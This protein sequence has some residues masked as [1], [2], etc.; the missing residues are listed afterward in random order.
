MNREISPSQGSKGTPGLE[1]FSRLIVA[2]SNPRDCSFIA[3]LARTGIR[4]SEAVQIKV[5]QRRQ[6]MIPIDHYTLQLLEVYLQ[7]RRRYPY[8]GTL[9]FPISRVRGWQLVE[10][11]GRRAGIKE[12][13]PHTLR[14]LLATEWVNKGLDVKK[15]QLLL[16]HAGITTTMRYV[17][18]SFDQLR[19]EYEKLWQNKEDDE[20]KSKGQ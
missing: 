8:R 6:R 2:T 19:A 20:R 13:H 4:I 5:E 14:H 3:V 7:W 16:G 1:T 12:L 17:D 15:L 11:I 18:A 9:L 10:R